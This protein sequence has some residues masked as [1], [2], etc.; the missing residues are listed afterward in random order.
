MELEGAWTKIC[1]WRHTLKEEVQ[2]SPNRESTN[3]P[4]VR[5]G[6]LVRA[7]LINAQDAALAPAKQT[8]IEQDG[9]TKRKSNEITNT[10]RIIRVDQA[11][12]QKG[13]LDDQARMYVPTLVKA[14]L[15]SVRWT[16]VTMALPDSG[17]L[18]AQAVINAEFHKK[19]GVPMEDTKIR[20]R[21]ANQQTLEVQGVSKIPQHI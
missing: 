10:S 5:R 6:F 11:S 2:W 7:K 1:K 9:I 4:T 21:A 12:H 8:N 19:L 15:G 17:N 3:S 18:L 20:A 16:R 14:G 13:T